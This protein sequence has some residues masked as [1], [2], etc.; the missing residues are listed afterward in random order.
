MAM[1]MPGKGKGAGNVKGKLNDTIKNT[2]AAAKQ[3]N[4][5]VVCVKATNHDLAAPKGKHVRVIMQGLQWGGSLTNRE[6]P[7]GGIYYH[8]RKRMMLNQS[9]VALKALTIFHHIFRDGN[10]KFVDYIAANQRSI[11]RM[12]FFGDPSPEAMMYTP[13]IRTY[14]AYIEQWCAMRAA[15][16]FPPGKSKDGDSAITSRYRDAPVEELLAALPVLMDSLTSMFALELGGQIKYSPVATPAFS[17]IFR[18]LTILW[19]SLSEGMIHLLSLF[20]SLDTDKARIAVDVYKRFVSLANTARPF[21]EVART[22]NA[23]WQVPQLG[24]IA[25]DLLDS[26]EKYVENGPAE[27]EPAFS[28]EEVYDDEPPPEPEPEPYYEPEPEYYSEE[29]PEPEPEPRRMPVPPPL[30]SSSSSSSEVEESETESESSDDDGLLPSAPEPAPAAA[31]APPKAYDP[32]A[33]MLGITSG[34]G[35]QNGAA[36]GG[37]YAKQNAAQGMQLQLYGAAG[38][39]MFQRA[40]IEQT[41]DERVANVKGLMAAGG[42]QQQ[43]VRSGF[44]VDGANMALALYGGPAAVQQQQAAM[45]QQQMQ[46]QQQMYNTMAMQQQQM[47]AYNT[48]AYQSMAAGG[49]SPQQQQQMMMQQQQQQQMMQQQQMVRQQQMMMGGRGGGMG[50]GVGMGVGGGMRNGGGGPAAGVPAMQAERAPVEPAS[51]KVQ[52]DTKTTRVNAGDQAFGD[53]LDQMKKTSLGNK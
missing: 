50:M 21:F 1:G 36:N 26:M 41:V 9:V 12:D 2:M 29:E 10:E 15:V 8:L 53:I 39:G 43:G 35:D 33:D 46:Q 27:A 45:Q 34:V 5:K 14:G 23:R 24:A 49:Y 40:G 18:D 20:F 16:H 48:M 6:S 11:F 47:A 25:L 28:D 37:L 22:I 19:V 31:P 42:G 13:L 38:P 17:M 52:R 30:S 7:A 51:Y 32:L 44:G 3:D 4:W